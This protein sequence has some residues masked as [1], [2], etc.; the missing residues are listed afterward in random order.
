[1]GYC[2]GTASVLRGYCGGTAGLPRG[3][4]TRRCPASGRAAS[5]RGSAPT[6]QSRSPD[7]NNS[8][9]PRGALHIARG[10]YM[11]HAIYVRSPRYI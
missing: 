1:M 6:A 9:G 11:S 7:A 2:V 10:I 4:C 3:P 8:H 5:S